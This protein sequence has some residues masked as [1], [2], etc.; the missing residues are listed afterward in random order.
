MPPT[1]F[2]I[3]VYSFPKQ[4]RCCSQGVNVL[5]KCMYWD[6]HCHGV[7]VGRQVLKLGS[8][9]VG[10]MSRSKSGV[11]SGLPSTTFSSLL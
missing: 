1:D 5:P 4:L 8:R 11:S 6:L 3:I 2:Y 9:C 10:H 7:D